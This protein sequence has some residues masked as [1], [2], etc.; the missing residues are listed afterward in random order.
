MN[1]EL[2]HFVP[3]NLRVIKFMADVMKKNN[4]SP[5]VEACR[6]NDIDTINL[7]IE[8]G[9]DVNEKPKEGQSPVFIS[10]L[11]KNYE[12]VKLLISRGVD[13]NSTNK[14]GETILMNACRFYLVDLVR[15][16]LERGA[17]PNLRDLSGENALTSCIGGAGFIG[18]GN[19]QTDSRRS[20]TEIV[21][22]L[23]SYKADLNSHSSRVDSP[24]IQACLNTKLFGSLDVVNL[25]L[26][27]GADVNGEDPMKMTALFKACQMSHFSST[28]ETVKLLLERGA[29]VKVKNRH[30]YTAINFMNRRLESDEKAIEIIKMLVDHGESVDALQ[31]NVAR[32][33]C[34]YMI[35]LEK[36]HVQRVVEIKTLNSLSEFSI[37]KHSVKQF[38]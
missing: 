18:F 10:L 12:T 25:L 32:K 5:L 36:A 27:N 28:P 34:K 20:V 7:L 17:D 24:L 3:A 14:Q 31:N 21:K 16:L 23:I 4:M 35:K 15:F 9:E 29:N 8:C 30:G 33:L 1:S 37:F 19:T 6:A 38:L 26:D 13:V 11:T 22:M 2:D